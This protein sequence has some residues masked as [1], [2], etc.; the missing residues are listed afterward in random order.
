M[1]IGPWISSLGACNGDVNRRGE[2]SANC[3]HYTGKNAFG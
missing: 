3:W 1:K 2:T